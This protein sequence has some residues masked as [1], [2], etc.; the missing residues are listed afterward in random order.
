MF[1]NIETG[2]YMYPILGYDNYSVSR[3]GVVA[4]CHRVSGNADKYQRYTVVQPYMNGNIPTVK[5]YKN[6]KY[7]RFPVAKLNI[8]SIYGELPFKIGYRDEDP[9]NVIQ[10]NLYYKYTD[11]RIQD[12]VEVDGEYFPGKILIMS[13]NK[14]KFE[15]FKPIPDEYMYNNFRYWISSKG[16][17]FDNWRKCLMSRSNDDRGYYK[18]A[19]QI[20][21]RTIKGVYYSEFRATP[22]IHALVYVAWADY[23]LDGLTI[24]HKDGRRHNNDIL[25]LEKVTMEENIRRAHE[26]N[27]EDANVI[28]SKWSTAQ[29]RVVCQMLSEGKLYKEIAEALGF[30]TDKTSKE[31][32]SVANLCIAIRDGRVHQDIAKDYIIPD[33]TVT[34]KTDYKTPKQFDPEVVRQLCEDLVAGMRT[35]DVVDKY[36]D[37][38]PEG[39]IRNIKTGVQYRE[40]ADT[41]P[42]MD[43]IIN[44]RDR[45]SDRAVERGLKVPERLTREEY[46]A[47]RRG[48]RKRL[49]AAGIKREANMQTTP[50]PEYLPEKVIKRY[51]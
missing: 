9:T 14:G 26:R 22:K 42:G 27:L 13:D 32:R 11:V 15:L 4:K 10:D 6:N 48:E 8:N 16:A 21:G 3:S 40:V 29:I 51:A 34:W 30:S 18:V 12:G 43:E 7:A 1:K 39:T 47:W 17:L 2:E 37:R 35:K 25:N 28:R 46:Y 19:L 5:L 23:D 33:N 45:Y 50:F 44:R 41:V 49:R 38:I 31:Y 36:K 24:D 20:P